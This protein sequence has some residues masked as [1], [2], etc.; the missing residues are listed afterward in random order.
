MRKVTGRASGG[1][2]ARPRGPRSGP[3][4]VVGGAVVPAAQA[5]AGGAGERAGR[6]VRVQE[7]EEV[8]GQGGV[9]GLLEAGRGEG[10]GDVGAGGGGGGG[11]RLVRVQGAAVVFGGAELVAVWRRGIS[12]V[13]LSRLGGV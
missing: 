9:V 4:A 1:S 8:G 2:T 5:G 12:G 10:A 6:V 13:Q 7:G 3:V 11:G